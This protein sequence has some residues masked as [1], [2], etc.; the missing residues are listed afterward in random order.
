MHW[1]TH[2]KEMRS[3]DRKIAQTSSPGIQTRTD[4]CRKWKT[5][6]SVKQAESNYNKN[7]LWE[8]PQLDGKA[9]GSTARERQK[10]VYEGRSQKQLDQLQSS[11][12]PVKITWNEL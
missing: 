6:E 7:T 9:L 11:T 12:K 8:Q 4:S 1:W 10:L 2:P 5:Q 3:A